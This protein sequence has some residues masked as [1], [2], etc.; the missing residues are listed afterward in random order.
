MYRA[1]GSVDFAQ[2]IHDE[3]CGYCLR[4]GSWKKFIKEVYK[5][6]RNHRFCFWETMIFLSNRKLR[7]FIR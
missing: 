6:Q 5:R 1:N 4:D 2:E 3:P 7:F